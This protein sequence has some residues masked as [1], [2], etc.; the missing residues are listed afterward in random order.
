MKLIKQG[1]KG[2]E[3]RAIQYFLAGRKLYTGIVDGDFGP[4]MAKAVAAYQPSKGLKADAIIGN[5]TLGTMLADGLVLMETPD[6]T[7]PGKASPFPAGFP[8]RPAGV[9]P[10]TPSQ[11][12]AIFGKFSYV[13]AP[14]KSN[15]EAIRITD[16]WAEKNIVTVVI[17]QLKTLGIS[18]T[19]KATMH[20]LAVPQ[21]LALWQAWEDAG[22]LHLVLSWEGMWVARFIRGSRTTLSNHAKGS[23]FDIN[24][25]G[26]KLGATPA[27]VGKANSVRELVPL[28][29][30][31]GFYWGGWFSRSD[32][33][34]F[35]IRR[36][37]PADELAALVAKQKGLS[38]L[39]A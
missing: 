7:V 8:V 13:A 5:I 28:A 11:A 20:R 31:F 34:H 38:K 24:Y 21:T 17:P 15:P 27:A 3:V 22:L 10:L 32:G 36:I 18:T 29:I 30:A 26:N 14:T 25:A 6:T 39:D 4:K 2:S 12:D 37:M 1:S 33:M 9:N 16:G 35:E 23:A 19:G